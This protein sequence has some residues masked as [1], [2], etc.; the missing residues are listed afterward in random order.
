ML[1]TWLDT[2]ED[3]YPPPLTSELAMLLFVLMDDAVEYILD[4]PFTLNMIGQALNHRLNTSGLSVDDCYA[5]AGSQGIS[6]TDLVSMPEQDVWMYQDDNGVSG[7]S[8]VCDVL[9]CSMYKAAGIFGSIASEIQCTE[10]TNWD[11]YSLAIFNGNFQRP[12]QCVQAD[13]TLPYCQLMGEIRMTLPGYNTVK[14]F[15]HMREHCPSLPPAYFRPPN[16]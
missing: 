5:L 6:F 16:C 15:P 8:M 9:V 11:V 2:A 10:F 4:D 3:N 13:P 14:P 1:F 7:P 12:P